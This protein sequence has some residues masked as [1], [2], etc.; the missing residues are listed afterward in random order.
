MML[1]EKKRTDEII[2]WLC[3]EEDMQLALRDSCEK[4]SKDWQFH[5]KLFSYYY[6]CRV[7]MERHRA[8]LN[9]GEAIGFG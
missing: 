1:D 4:Y 9:K 2:E 8:S 5:Q 3:E 6:K 7:I